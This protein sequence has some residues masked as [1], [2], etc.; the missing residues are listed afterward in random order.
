MV[1]TK[2]SLHLP[3]AT[4]DI[5]FGDVGYND[6]NK[7]NHYHHNNGVAIVWRPKAASV[8]AV[9]EEEVNQDQA[10]GALR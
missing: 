8:L 5:S 7:Y 1:H 3:E 9:W 2:V 4:A 10:R 6:D